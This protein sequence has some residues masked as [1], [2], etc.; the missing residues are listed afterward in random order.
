MLG[1]DTV[2]HGPGDAAVPCPTAAHLV[3]LP[4]KPRVCLSSCVCAYELSFH[5]RKELFLADT[6]QVSVLALSVAFKPRAHA[7]AERLQELRH[8]FLLN[9]VENLYNMA[10]SGGSYFRLITP[11]PTRSYHL[12]TLHFGKGLAEHPPPG[13]ALLAAV[14]NPS[15]AR[16]EPGTPCQGVGLLLLAPSISS[17]RMLRWCFES[18][19]KGKYS[20]FSHRGHNH[21]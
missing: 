10:Q 8:M 9:S 15:G 11:E 16:S 2:L 20:V 13:P 21:L 12:V 17:M 1:A 7:F 18:F 6:N 19:R 4:K 3:P 14:P 5:L